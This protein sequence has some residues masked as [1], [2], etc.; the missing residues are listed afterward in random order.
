MR[1][2]LF[3]LDGTL[4]DSEPIVTRCFAETMREEAGVDHDPS[5]YRHFIGPP[6]RSSFQELGVD[7]I[8]Y[9]VRAYRSRYAQ[10]MYETLLFPGISGLL[11]NLASAGIPLAVATSK[12]EESAR[13][14]LEYLGVAGNFTVICGSDALEG[15]AGKSEIIADALAALRAVGIATADA[16]MVGDRCYDTDGAAAN[17]MR[18]ILVR[19]G[20]ARE[21]EY[22][23]AWRTAATVEELEVI[24]R[25]AVLPET[26]PDTA[27]RM[28]RREQ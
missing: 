14:L 23:Q 19:W 22:V 11:K 7:D 12:R 17:G 3:D 13:D 6:L 10:H 16:L 25:D 26:A 4:T 8:A 5:F 2:V 21:E 27:A 1:P 20:A 28:L 15:R 18:T 9:Y 24:I